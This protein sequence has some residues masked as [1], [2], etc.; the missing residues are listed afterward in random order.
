MMVKDQERGISLQQDQS[1]EYEKRGLQQQ[2]RIKVLKDKIILLEKSLQQIV[3]DFEKEKEL[4]KFQHE[5]IIADQSHDIARCREVLRAKNRELK[6][7]RA[8]AQVMLSQRS[9]IEQ[10][11]LEALEQ[12]KEEIRKKIAIERKQKRSE[13]GGIMANQQRQDQMHYAGSNDSSVLAAGSGAQSK[14][15]ADGEQKQYT[16]KVD[17]NDLDWEDRERVLRL[18]FSKMNAG[19]PAN[20]HKALAKATVNQRMQQVQQMLDYQSALPPADQTPPVE[21]Y[22]HDQN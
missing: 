9:E 5:K 13:F 17:L 11:F 6:N 2:K 3:Y 16:D 4:L 22:D 18:L 8:L 7:I 15:N 10:F 1:E 20:A 19:V 12:I 21:Y 14:L